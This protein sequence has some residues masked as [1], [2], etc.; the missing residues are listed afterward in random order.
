MNGYMFI[1]FKTKVKQ[2]RVRRKSSKTDVV[3]LQD[4]FSFM[5]KTR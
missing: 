2:N 5:T 4:I 1:H 3:I